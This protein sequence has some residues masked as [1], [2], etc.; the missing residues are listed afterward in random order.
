ML[1]VKKKNKT[2]IVKTFFGEQWKEEELIGEGSYGKVYKAKKEEFGIATY[3]AIKQI[4]IPQDKAEIQTLKTEG[5]TQSNITTYYEK[6]VKKWVEEIKFM[7]IF[8]DSENIVNIEDYEIVKKKNE[9]GWIINI[10]MELLKNLDAYVLENNITDKEMLKMAIDIATALEDCEANKVIHRDIKPDNIFVN[11]KGVYKLGDFGIAKHI[12]KTVS[13]MSKKGT[14]NYMAPELYKNEKGNKTVDVYSLGIMLYR[15][16]NYNRLPFLPD[17][18]EEIT[19]EA[20]EE[21]LY[22]RISGE[23]LKAPQNATREIAEIIL[24]A[25]SYYPKDRYSSATELKEDLEKVYNGIEKP[26]VLFD[27]NDKKMQKIFTENSKADTHDGTLS[28]MTGTNETAKDI[29]KELNTQAQD[30]QA[31]HV[32]T[33]EN[34]HEAEQEKYKAS[35]NNINE[36]NSNIQENRN[37]EQSKSTIEKTEKN[38]ETQNITNAENANSIVVKE[39]KV[40]AE[41]DAK[42]KKVKEKEKAQK[43]ENKI[44]SEASIKI[45]R[46]KKLIIIP[47]ILILLAIIIV[48]AV[49]KLRPQEPEIIQYNMISVVGMESELATEELKKINC[50]VEYEYVETENEEEIG[51][52]LEQSIPEN[53]L[54]NE[55]TVV[56]LKVAVSVTKVKV[57]DVTGKTKEEAQKE[58]E[59]LGL[60]VTFTEQN[61]EEVE[62]DK[63]IS[64]MPEEGEEV[65]VGTI[66][67][68]LVSLGNEVVENEEQNNKETNN[69][70]NNSNNN[71][72]N[73]LTNNQ[74]NNSNNSNDNSTQSPS[75]PQNE[76]SSSTSEE[77][78][79]SNPWSNWVE[80]LP[81]GITS[82]NYNIETKTQYSTRTRSIYTTTVYYSFEQAKPPQTKYYIWLEGT[83]TT[84]KPTESDTLRIMCSL[85]TYSSGY[86]YYHVGSKYS[87]GSVSGVGPGTSADNS[88]SFEAHTVKSNKYLGEKIGGI[89]TDDEIECPICGETTW[90][91]LDYPAGTTVYLYQTRNKETEYTYYVWSSWTDYTDEVA[92]PSSTLQVRTKTLYRYQ[93]K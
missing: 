18:P 91:Y 9:I 41:K 36:G 76:P 70:G 50:E 73:N 4:E 1:G 12:E 64:Q 88:A 33:Q 77:S 21:A 48:F 66:I 58:L 54:V 45:K 2:Q 57:I 56:T 3:S 38:T 34:L 11:K 49:I 63:I 74:N 85:K 35:Q 5:M 68:L 7:S 29:P 82:S 15:Y 10:R 59:E 40:E 37:T 27:Y 30:M 31:E 46:H 72:N 93:S 13:N 81:S 55:G 28:I 65:N 75:K 32:A 86:T 44:K 87:D 19:L 16:F 61:N 17:Y 90:W 47:I 67:E 14:E 84:K 60:L 8:K 25:C 53:E 42:K 89:F 39:N 22:K 51:K 78:T 79:S 6:T 71:T 83:M 69:S 80:T 92:T 23:K 43:S 52:V 24:K 20:R 26:R 62:K